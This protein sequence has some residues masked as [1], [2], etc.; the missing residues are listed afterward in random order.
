MGGPPFDPFE[1]ARFTGVALVPREDLDDARLVSSE[2][3]TP[4]IEFNPSRRPTRVRFSVAHELG[5]LLFS[6]HAERLRYRNESHR[7]SA[8]QDD[9]QLE[10]L[11]NI[12]AAEILMPVGALP[13]RLAEDLSLPHLLDLRERFVVSTEALLRRVVKLTSRPVSLFSAVRLRDATYRVD[14]AVPSHAWSPALQ[15]G[16]LVPNDTVLS[17]CT[18]VGYTAAATE[19]WQGSQM[20]VQ[21][22]GVPPYP[23]DR[24]PR[25]LGLL[26]PVSAP[27]PHSPALSYV[28]GDATEPRREGPTII[29]HV[30]NNTARRWG[31]RG[32]AVTLARR[33]PTAR[34]GYAE[35]AASAAH[36]RLGQ[37]HLA[38]V[39]A[40]LWIASLVAQAGYGPALPNR[41]RL[42][43]AALR[44]ALERLA[45][46]AN[47]RGA[48][49]AMPPIG[50]GQAGGSWPVV[51][52]L[53]IDEIALRGIQITV[54]VLPTDRMPDDGPPNDQPVQLPPRS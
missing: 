8:R 4:R 15:Q 45:L 28:R 37:V 38:Q 21:A 54:H 53:V 46:L 32:F 25:V 26:Q 48:S 1:L 5:H 9:W 13:A 40:G 20:A 43:V 14:Y 33:Y 24:F 17:H 27:Q 50:T 41:P 42:R 31:G 12:A 11:S 7:E 2:L 18:A 19:V 3:E 47:E 36:L 30:V 22:V 23:G 29:A 49:I 34:D 35:W 10:V 44:E 6:D 16:F 39:E 52:D 51:R